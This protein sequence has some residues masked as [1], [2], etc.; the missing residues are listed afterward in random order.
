MN[1]PTP[2]QL[3]RIQQLIEALESGEYKQIKGKLRVDEKYCALGLACKIFH[4]S[5]GK[6]E[7]STRTLSVPFY[8]RFDEHLAKLPQDV[9]DYFGCVGD[10]WDLPLDNLSVTYQNDNGKTFPE[11]AAILR[12]TYFPESVEVT[13]DQK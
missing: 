5:T 13:R 1:R 8:Y 3:E 4:D 10:G 11:I 7:W 9:R 2:E 12:Q 6:G